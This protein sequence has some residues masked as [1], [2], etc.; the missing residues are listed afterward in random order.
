MRIGRART[1]DRVLA[2]RP[3]ELHP[4]FCSTI[5]FPHDRWMRLESANEL[6][7]AL[8]GEFTTIMKRGLALIFLLALSAGIYIGAAAKPA[9]VDEADREIIDNGKPGRETEGLAIGRY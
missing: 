9:L 4:C 8:A 3:E 6:A 1:P 2:S 7:P 5:G